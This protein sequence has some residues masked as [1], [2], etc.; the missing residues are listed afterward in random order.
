MTKTNKKKKSQQPNSAGQPII[1]LTWQAQVLEYGKAIAVAVVLALII[2]SFI[3]QAFHI[4]SGSMIPTI[5]EGDRVLVTKFSFGIRNPFTNRVLINTGSPKRGDVVIFMYP[6]DP[7]TDFVK[8]V[9]GLPGE[10]VEI[11]NGQI[12]INDRFIEDD[13]GHYDNPFQLSSR[14][15]GPAIVPEGHYFMMGDNRDYSN[16]S[17]VWGF[18][19][20]SLLRGKAWRMYW[21]WNPASG[22]PFLERL[23]TDRLWR[24]VD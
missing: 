24:K 15:F 10:K 22:I 21:S 12:K 2:R 6:D 3:I 8:R 16:D 1:T 18:V 7:A 17:R 23:R 5:L 14:N 4:P 20:F 13:H 19:D 11:V 9:I